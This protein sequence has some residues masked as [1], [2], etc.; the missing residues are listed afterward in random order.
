MSSRFL[1]CDSWWGH[2]HQASALNGNKNQNTLKV[3]IESG[4]NVPWVPEGFFPLLRG[5]LMPRCGS[6][7]RLRSPLTVR[8]KEKKTSGTQGSDNEVFSVLTNCVIH[9]WLGNNKN[10]NQ[11]HY[12]S[13]SIY[14]AGITSPRKEPITWLVICLVPHNPTR[15]RILQQSSRDRCCY[16]LSTGVSTWSR[17]DLQ[18]Q[19]LDYGFRVIAKLSRPRFVLSASAFAGLQQINNTNLGLNLIR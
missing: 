17:V 2:K 11:S 15:R 19:L 13:V 3:L 7:S 12:I 10:N 14:I 8:A 9:S 5:T 4:N 1:W 16:S 6:L 18:K